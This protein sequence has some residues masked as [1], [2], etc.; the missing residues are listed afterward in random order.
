VFQYW[1]EA[2]K[3]QELADPPIFASSQAP[4]KLSGDA[5]VQKE[6]DE[7]LLIGVPCGMGG[8]LAWYLVRSLP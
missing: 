7:L 3:L 5:M 4:E 1:V 2:W 6:V 8:A